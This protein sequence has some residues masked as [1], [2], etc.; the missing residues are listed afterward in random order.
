ML[1][2]ALV[3]AVFGYS[4]NTTAFHL[5]ETYT[6]KNNGTIYLSLH[7]AGVSIMG[8]NRN[9][10]AVKIDYEVT[11]KGIEW[12]SREFNIEVTN[13]DGDLHIQ[14]YRKSN[15]GL[16]GYSSSHY[17]VVIKA[18]YASNW[19]IKG[20][21]DNYT[22]NTIKGSIRIVAD[23]AEA[24]LENCGGDSFY[25]DLDDGSITMDRATGQLTARM[26]DG[27]L[28]IANA[29]LE[30]IDYRSDDGEVSLQTT[31]GPNAMFKFIG[32]DTDYDIVV[33][34]GGGTFTIKHDDGRIDY[35]SNFRLMDKEEN[36]L[37][38]SLTGGRGKVIISGDDIKV[39]LA[40][41]E[42]R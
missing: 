25:F 42:A 38:L 29:T 41:K 21:D 1:T 12:G 26:D 23:D 11:T 3:T 27:K 13:Q 36:R 24:V 17:K 19:A 7:D 28:T 6:L 35:D 18:P 4:Q 16:V 37:V 40:A 10:V 20:D 2:L 39:N 15:K 5:D 22:I 9:D 32:D 30:T 34:R 14:E 33:T 31:V 8:E